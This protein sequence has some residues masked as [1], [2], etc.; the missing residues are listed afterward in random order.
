MSY[1]IHTNNYEEN[2]KQLQDKVRELVKLDP[3][4]IT[5]YVKLYAR[6][7]KYGDPDVILKTGRKPVSQHQQQ[8]KKETYRKYYEKVKQK[9]EEERA[10]LDA[11]GITYKKK[12][13]RPKKNPSPTEEK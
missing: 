7:K 1:L 5:E 10:Q 3:T 8:H 11:L 9:R 4:L 12:M 6:V 13:G 2:K